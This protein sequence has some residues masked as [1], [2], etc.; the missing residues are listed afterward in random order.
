MKNI[1]ILDCTLR[2]GGYYTNWDFSNELVKIYILAM[3]N[4]KIDIIEI[5]FRFI[6]K[7][8]YFGPY[9][10]STDN[11]ISNLNIPLTIK[12]G[13]MLNF[14][15]ILNSKDSVVKTLDSVFVKKADS[16]VSL[17]RIA[18]HVADVLK[19][20]ETAQHLTSLGYTV[21]LN[22]M[23]AHKCSKDEFEDFS[24]EI[25]QWNSVDVLYFADTLGNMQ[26]KNII[27]TID[28]LSTF[29]KAPLGLHAHDNMGQAEHNAISAIEAGATWI[30]VTVM[31]M[32]RG[33]G[34]LKTEN[35]LLKLQQIGIGNYKA[36]ALF[37][38]VTVDFK[39]LMD[40]YN[41]GENVFYYL[42]AMYNIH[43]SYV[44]EMQSNTSY[45]TSDKVGVLK[46]LHLNNGES[47]SKK[48]LQIANTSNSISSIGEWDSTN[49]TKGKDILILAGSPTLK[50][51]SEAIQNFVGRKK[52]IVISLNYIDC[53]DQNLVDVYSSCYLTKIIS[54]LDDLSKINKPL[55]VPM[56]ALPENI[57]NKLNNV[58]IYNYGMFVQEETFKSE[59]TQ[60]II[61]SPLVFAYALSSLT[62]TDT[63]NIYLAG[64]DGYPPNDARNDEMKKVIDLFKKENR[65]SSLISLTPTIY[66]VHKNS[67][68]NPDV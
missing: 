64:F 18:V 67:I 11:F 10:Y 30:D 60:C 33:A 66:G 43:P 8:E 53:I 38:L 21:G 32:G 62:N 22:I 55:L 37:E 57:K 40:K 63:K 12:I 4:A 34:N 28:A 61:P 9:A 7:S 15:D 44:Q 52:P 49:W 68:Y 1:N 36:E 58:N 31:G 14:A 45:S 20:E 2:D 6:N 39:K 19:V 23:Q 47:F 35:L 42:S 54:Q 65:G 16:P 17:V 5:G 24:K 26:S 27:D 25:A 51:Y 29:W 13:V 3:S 41:W 48:S 59:K 56:N 50:N 46:Y